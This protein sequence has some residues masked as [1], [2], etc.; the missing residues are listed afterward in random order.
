M[1]ETAV[2]YVRYSG[3]ASLLGQRP[4]LPLLADQRLVD[5]G[6]D[7]ATGDG[8]LDQRVQLLVPT[9]GELQVAGGDP[10]HLQVLTGVTGQLEHL[11][12]EVL[13][14]GGAV[15]RR[16]GAHAPGREGAAL[17]VTVDPRKN[18]N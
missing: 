9:D 2:K 11:S 10:L 6:D 17:Q 3:G 16:S 5:V 15:H 8:G 7:A 13:Q 1:Y 18:L 14:D 12:C 4:T